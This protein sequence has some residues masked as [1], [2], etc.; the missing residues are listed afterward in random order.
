L[1][2]SAHCT[3]GNQLKNSEPEEQGQAADLLFFFEGIAE[4]RFVI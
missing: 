3:H 1:I 2:V 4:R